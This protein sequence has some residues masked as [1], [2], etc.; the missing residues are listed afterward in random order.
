MFIRP[1]RS[2]QQR[3][4]NGPIL[5]VVSIFAVIQQ[6]YS[7]IALGDIRPAMPADLK[8]CLFPAGVV[9]CG[10]FQRTKRDF[11]RCFRSHQ[12]H[13]KGYLEQLMTLIPADLGLEIHPALM[14]IKYD[15]LA[16]V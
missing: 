3:Q 5:D 13:W 16:D 14:T 1:L 15:I 4:A 8:L 7:A 9:M 11:I 2:T 12:I 10:A 6:T